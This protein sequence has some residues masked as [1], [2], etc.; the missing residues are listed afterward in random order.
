MKKALI[1]VLCGIFLVAACNKEE[2]VSP[3]DPLNPNEL[4]ECFEDG[5]WDSTLIAQSLV[6]R[7]RWHHQTCW[8][9]EQLEPGTDILVRFRENGTFLLAEEGNIK[10]EG[11]WR[12]TIG[13]NNLFGCFTVPRE[14]LI[15]G[16]VRF[17]EDWLEFN[18]GAIDG[19]NNFYYSLD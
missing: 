2:E 9:P 8:G 13:T 17:C 11:E 18:Q 5:S 7:W 10:A 3:P 19:C 16:G 15:T 1:I 6:G 4:R 14:N 12:I